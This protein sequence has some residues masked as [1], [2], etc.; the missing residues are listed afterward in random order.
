VAEF[1][2]VRAGLAPRGP[3]AQT[4]LLQRPTRRRKVALPAQGACRRRRCRTFPSCVFCAWPWRL[5]SRK[6]LADH[7]GILA[8][9]FHHY[10]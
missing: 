7:S 9:P 10:L 3:P 2:G 5:L 4:R 1:A 6:F 8:A